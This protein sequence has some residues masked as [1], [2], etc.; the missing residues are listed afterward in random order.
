MLDPQKHYKFDDAI[1]SFFF[2]SVSNKVL[3]SSTTTYLPATY[4]IKVV[5]V[6]NVMHLVGHFPF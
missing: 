1:S 4:V 5:K 6:G 3:L 2:N